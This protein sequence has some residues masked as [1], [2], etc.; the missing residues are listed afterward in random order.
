MVIGGK[1]VHA[2]FTFAANNPATGA[3]AS[4]APNGEIE[5]LDAAVAAAKAAFP[6]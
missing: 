4:E 1:E 2:A 5:H 6:A 3:P